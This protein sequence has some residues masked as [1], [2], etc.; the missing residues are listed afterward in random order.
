MLNRILKNR[1]LNGN[2]N[3]EREHATCNTMAALG[4]TMCVE[5]ISLMTY[6]SRNS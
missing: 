3:Q 4:T 2:V 1:F 5:I 6:N